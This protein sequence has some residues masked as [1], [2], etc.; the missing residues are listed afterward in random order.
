MSYELLGI[1]SNEPSEWPRAKKKRAAE[2]SIPIQS[3]ASCRTCLHPFA[4]LS[5]LGLLSR[6]NLAAFVLD[7][8][9]L[10]QSSLSLGASS[11]Q[12]LPRPSPHFLFHRL[13]RALHG[14]DGLHDFHGFHACRKVAVLLEPTLVTI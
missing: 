1:A 12:H 9:G 2:C 3:F 13:H 5:S 14:F 4:L 8:I 6:D 11:L 10:C 7:Q